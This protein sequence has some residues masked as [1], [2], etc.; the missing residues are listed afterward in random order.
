MSE[1]TD[2][3]RFASPISL[4]DLHVRAPGTPEQFAD[5][6]AM[7]R[8]KGLVSIEGPVADNLHPNILKSEGAKETKVQLTDLG[9]KSLAL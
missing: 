4:R 9:F 5:E 2:I 3:L 7:L 6:L 1:L 8:K